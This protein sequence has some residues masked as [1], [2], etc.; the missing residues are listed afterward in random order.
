MLTKI[1][2]G[3]L[4]SADLIGFGWRNESGKSRIRAYSKDQMLCEL[5]I[6]TESA[7]SVATFCH[8]CLNAADLSE[9]WKTILASLKV[10]DELR[11][12]WLPDHDSN[13]YVSTRG[14]H[15]DVLQ[16]IVLRRTPGNSL[17]RLV[18]HVLTSITPNNAVRLVQGIRRR[19]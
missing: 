3:A 10:G 8:A 11:L 17:R 16:L 9:P 13:T 2:I 6:E 1:H 5:E 15:A 12:T 19:A 18:F 14:L 4:K 7:P